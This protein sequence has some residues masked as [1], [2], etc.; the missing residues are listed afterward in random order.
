MNVWIFFFY[1]ALKNPSTQFVSP[2]EFVCFSLCRVKFVYF[3]C[4]EIAEI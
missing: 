4:A 3:R 2:L 1:K